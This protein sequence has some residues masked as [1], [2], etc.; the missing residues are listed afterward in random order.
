M[1]V[2][3]ECWCLE[4]IKPRRGYDEKKALNYDAIAELI[5]KRKL[6]EHTAVTRVLDW[7]GSN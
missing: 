1:G 5:D 3:K 7:L 4:W 2:W 6:T